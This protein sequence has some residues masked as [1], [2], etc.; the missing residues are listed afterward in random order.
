MIKIMI[1]IDLLSFENRA[2]V[3]KYGEEKRMTGEKGIFVIRLIAE[4]PH[5]VEHCP[6]FKYIERNLRWRNALENMKTGRCDR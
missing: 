1:Y 5:R 6:V 2:D 3:S 4:I